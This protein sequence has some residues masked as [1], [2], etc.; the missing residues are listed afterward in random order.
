MMLH[1][2]SSRASLLKLLALVP[3]VGVALAMQ[4]E[5]VNEYVFTEKTQNPPQKI[6]KKGKTNAQVKLGN[7]TIEVKAEQ[8]A[9][10]DEKPATIESTRIVISETPSEH[11]PLLILDGKVATREQ[12]KALNQDEIG[13]MNVLKPGD[14]DLLRAYGKHYNADTS[15]GIIFI[16]TKAHIEK[17]KANPKERSV[18]VVVKAK[19]KPQTLEEAAAQGDIAIGAIDYDKPEKPFDVVEQKSELPDSTSKQ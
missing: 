7:K 10:K 9:K 4:A 2:N 15:N 11:E 18:V 16:R 3:I 8:K 5:T 6:V 13:D 14:E 1:K 12:V 19:K 17:Q